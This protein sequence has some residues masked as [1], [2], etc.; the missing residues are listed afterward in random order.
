MYESFEPESIDTKH[1]YVGNVTR[2][3][4][5]IQMDLVAKAKC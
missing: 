1:G 3:T 5:F 4:K 2:Q